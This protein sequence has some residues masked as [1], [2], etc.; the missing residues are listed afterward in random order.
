[1]RNNPA[2]P[3]KLFLALAGLVVLH[4]IV[5]WNYLFLDFW[6][7]ELYTLE[8]FA[9]VPISRTLTDYHLPNNHVFFSLLLNLV[10]GLFG[11]ESVSEILDHPDWLRAGMMLISS[12]TVVLVFLTANRWQ[13]NSG[14]WAAAALI[15]T[16]PFITFAMQIRGYS[17]SMMLLAVLLWSI[18]RFKVEKK[19]SVGIILATALLAYTLPSNYYVLLS[20]C[21]AMAVL[22]AV[23]R[24]RHS[25]NIGLN[26]L[27]GILLSLLL[28]SP[29]FSDVFFNRFV[30]SSAPFSIDHLRMIVPWI[31][32]DLIGKRYFLV[33]LSAIGIFLSLKKSG[34][35]SVMGLLAALLTLPFLVSFVRGDLPFIRSFVFMAVPFSIAVGMGMEHLLSFVPRLKNARIGLLLLFG[36][37]GWFAFQNAWE[38]S[39][40]ECLYNIEH[41][42][43]AED[44]TTCYFQHR[45][46]PLL[47]VEHFAPIYAANPA[48]LYVHRCQPHDIRFYLEPQNIQSVYHPN[49][50][51][52]ALHANHFY[53]VSENPNELTNIFLELDS[54]WS[55][56]VLNPKLTYHT[57]LEFSK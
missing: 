32:E 5:Q 57:F 11:I 26:L 35:R 21:V 6:S 19:F 36:F 34:I 29:I 45:Y 7:D 52:L 23:K 50:D 27:G 18:A 17:L 20:A 55:V 25:L 41:V 3:M 30:E 37:E 39:E 40:E 49:F 10:L 31:W 48:A 14:I 51:S 33:A 46:Q 42:H 47:D 1:M 13:K 2:I 4:C 24:E 38:S 15:F 16:V 8:N 56:R 12:T 44:L 53:A 9:L 54:N 28:L 43:H 22:F